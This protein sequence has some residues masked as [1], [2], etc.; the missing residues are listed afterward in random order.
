[1]CEVLVLS[2]LDFLLKDRLGTLKV[3]WINEFVPGD[4]GTCGTGVCGL[5]S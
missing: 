4:I 1:M 5:Y 3:V 2:L